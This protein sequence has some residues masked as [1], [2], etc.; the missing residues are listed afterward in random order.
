[1]KLVAKASDENYDKAE[2]ALIAT[3][4][5]RAKEAK[6]MFARLLGE[7]SDNG[8][9]TESATTTAMSTTQKDNR[10]SAAMQQ[11]ETAA[12]LNPKLYF[13]YEQISGKFDIIAWRKRIAHRARRTFRQAL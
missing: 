7:T 10:D 5:Q 8:T 4:K 9:E 11:F 1:M 12:R 6:E 13:L 2:A 3:E